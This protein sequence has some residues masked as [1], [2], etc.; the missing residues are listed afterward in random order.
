MTRST[1]DV[2]LHAGGVLLLCLCAVGCTSGC[3]FVKDSPQSGAVPDAPRSTPRQDDPVPAPPDEG[4]HLACSASPITAWRYSEDGIS[5]DDH[6]DM[7]GCSGPF[8]IGV[9]GGHGTIKQVGG[10]GLKYFPPSRGADPQGR[11]RED[12]VTITI[13]CPHHKKQECVMRIAIRL[14]GQAVD[15]NVPLPSRPGDIPDRGDR[16][17]RGAGT[18]ATAFVQPRHDPWPRALLGLPWRPTRSHARGA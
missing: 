7:T 9:L 5:I 6:L 14:P 16:A 17:G 3:K 2:R 13:E 18:S 10:R 12:E 4:C 1:W 8:T 11:I 15:P